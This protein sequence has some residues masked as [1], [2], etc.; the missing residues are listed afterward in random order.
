MK[1]KSMYLMLVTLLLVS[2]PAMAEGQQ[3]KMNQFIDQLMSK[4]TVGT[5]RSMPAGGASPKVR[6]ELYHLRI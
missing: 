5:L 3:E 1:F 2:I 4:M 6:T